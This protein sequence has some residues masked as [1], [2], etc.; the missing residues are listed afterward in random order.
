ML[1][2]FNHRRGN[3]EDDDGQDDQRKVPLHDRQVAKV[4]PPKDKERRPQEAPAD[5]IDH[6][7][8]IR[9]TTDASDK[10]G[11][12]TD[13]GNETGDNDRLAPVSLVELMRTLQMLPFEE[14]IL[15]VKGT[16]AKAVADA[17]VH[18]VTQ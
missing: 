15:T 9:H 16:W 5:V 7:P 11:E 12:R 14:T 3:R 6:E 8:P 13:D 18:C 2:P 10:G 17:V 1:D 4:I